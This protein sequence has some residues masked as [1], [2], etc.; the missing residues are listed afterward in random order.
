MSSVA[1]LVYGGKVVSL[2]AALKCL[3]VCLD[4]TLVASGRQSFAYH[5][6]MRGGVCTSCIVCTASDGP[7]STAHRLR[8]RLHL[9]ANRLRM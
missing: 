4:C 5:I 7:L 2:P 9:A 8:R 1:S 6:A 3:Q